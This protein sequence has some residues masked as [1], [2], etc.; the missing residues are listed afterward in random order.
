[1]MHFLLICHVDSN[2]VCIVILLTIENTKKLAKMLHFITISF[3]CLDNILV[4][5]SF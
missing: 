2:S 3:L 1:M 5:C 4:S